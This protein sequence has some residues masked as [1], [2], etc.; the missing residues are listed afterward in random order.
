MNR[1]RLLMLGAAIVAV[2]AVG[3]GLYAGRQSVDAPQ[4]GASTTTTAP[5]V[6]PE[7]PSGFVEFRDEE[8]GFAFSYP[9]EWLELDTEEEQVVLVVAEPKAATDNVGGAVLARVV[10]L[11]A[12][13]GPEQL[14]EAKNVTDAIVNEGEG[15]E[16]KAEP[17]QVIQAGLPGYY[18]LYTFAD[19]VTDGRGAHSHYFLFKDTLMITFV[20]QAV[21][22]GEFTRLAPVFDQIINSLRVL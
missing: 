12:E 15:V 9:E 13:I 22:E 1:K 10:P 11:G 19:P 14:A 6:A 17:A 21:P 2:A 7:T 18:Y 8:A 16:L 4:A 5:E 3:I 20:F